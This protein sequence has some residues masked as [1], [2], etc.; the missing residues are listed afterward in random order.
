[1][2]SIGFRCITG[3][4]MIFYFLR[5]WLDKISEYEEL[6][7]YGKILLY[8]MKP[9]ILCSTC[10]ASVHTLLWYPVLTGSFDILIIPV[11][12]IVAFMNTLIYG[13]IETIQKI[14]E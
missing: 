11:M 8:I 5:G 13:V 7:N 2:A 9:V 12:L 14:K 1:M 10:M 3:K 6:N 4:G